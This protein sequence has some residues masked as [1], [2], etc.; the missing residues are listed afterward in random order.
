MMAAGPGGV[1]DRRARDR[2]T[3]L[4][5]AEAAFAILIEEPPYAAN[6]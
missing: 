4:S 6:R 3:R 2:A 5:V 1:K